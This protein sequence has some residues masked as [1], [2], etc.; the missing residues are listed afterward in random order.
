[1]DINIINYRKFLGTYNAYSKKGYKEVDCCF[2]ITCGFYSKKGYNKTHCYIKKNIRKSK[3][4]KD[5]V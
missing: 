1:M 4:F 2:K 5:K 3:P